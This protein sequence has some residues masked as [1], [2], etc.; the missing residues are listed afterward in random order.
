MFLKIG[1]L[2][3]FGDFTGKHLCWSLRAC[4]HIKK[5]L[6]H[7]CF[8]VKFAEFLRTPFLQN[9]SGGRFC[10]VNMNKPENY[11]GFIFIY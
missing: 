9:T 1:V 7:S 2:K 11:Q 3:N 4:N 10:L 6:Q 5:R 8:P